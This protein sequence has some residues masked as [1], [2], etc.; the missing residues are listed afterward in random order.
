MKILSILTLLFVSLTFYGQI[1]QKEIY[2]VISED[3]LWGTFT[4]SQND[5][6]TSQTL[7]LIIAGSGPTDRDGNN[8]IMKNYSLQLLG[9]DLTKFGFPTI[10]YDKRGV[11]QSVNAYIPEAELTFNQNVIDAESFYDYAL[12][13]G[14]HNIAIAGHSEGSL[15][16]L[17]LANK[18]DAQQ[19]ISLA[20]AG[21]PI[22]EVLKEQYENTAPIVR[23]SAHAVIDILAQGIKVDTLSPWLYS[24]FRPQLQDYI[25]SW[26]ALDPALELAKFNHN[27]LIIQGTTDIQVAIKDA[28]KLHAS[29]PASEL[30][31]IEGMNHI[32]KKAPLDRNLNKKTYNQPELPLHPDLVLSIVNFLKK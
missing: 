7:V 21:R 8:N 18:R 31:I 14:Y 19:F 20:G 28:E 13:L 29:N 23:D 3:T 30:I 17:L 27:A 1:S 10:R 24:V 2:T 5:I 22:G 6:D 12:N 26:M 16:G 32:F 11:A 9:D 15:V 25:I 4:N